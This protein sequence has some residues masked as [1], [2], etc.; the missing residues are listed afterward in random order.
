MFSCMG[1]GVPYSYIL[2]PIH[3]KRILLLFVSGIL[4]FLSCKTSQKQEGGMIG[5]PGDNLNLYAVLKTFQ[6][7]PTLD[8]FERA[9]NDSTNKIN[10]LDLNGDGKI[11]YIRVVDSMQGN[12]HNIML[13]AELAPNEEQSVAVIVVSRNPD[14]TVNVQLVGDEALYGKNYI[15]EPN[16]RDS[17]AGKPNPAYQD[18]AN[19]GGQVVY[20]PTTPYEV[21]GWPIVGYIYM[22]GYSPWYSPW[23]WGYYPPYWSPWPPFSW[24]F[25]Y[26]YH[27]YWNYFYFGHYHRGRDYHNP[28]WHD[29][30]YGSPRMRPYSPIYQQHIARGDHRNTYNRP[31]DINAGADHFVRKFPNAPS[32]HYPP[33]QLHSSGRPDTRSHGGTNPATPRPFRSITPS[34]PSPSPKAPS[35]G[36][37][38]HN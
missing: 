22:P 14:Q 16:Y 38:K 37:R 10:N 20:A 36:G 17:L 28:G 29:A 24:H 11:D 34:R 9:L 23:Y 35:G 2:Q 26:G 7:S 31:M 30:F 5:L 27:F 3:M 19:D 32:S 12:L 15:V 25:Y 21:A 1:E 6:E 13:R 8:G 18:N 33:P 4:V